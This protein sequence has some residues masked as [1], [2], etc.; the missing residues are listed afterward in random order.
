LDKA[1]TVLHRL[2]LLVHQVVAVVHRPLAQMSHQ[3]QVAQVAQ[4]Q[5]HL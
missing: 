2:A 1:I 5:H 4:E 3:H